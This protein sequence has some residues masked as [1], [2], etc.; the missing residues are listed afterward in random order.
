ME[1]IPKDTVDDSANSRTELV[2]SVQG[3]PAQGGA[4]W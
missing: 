2:D 3:Q 1:L 4:A